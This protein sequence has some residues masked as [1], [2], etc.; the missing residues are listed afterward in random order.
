VSAS[1]A[2]APK[3][4]EAANTAEA[5]LNAATLSSQGLLPRRA[6]KACVTG[7][8]GEVAFMVYFLSVGRGLQK[9]RRERRSGN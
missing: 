3:T 4:S 2:E 9:R 7:A 5:V 6:L 8:D 1:A